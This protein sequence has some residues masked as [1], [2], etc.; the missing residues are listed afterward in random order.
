MKKNKN[1]N[2]QITKNKKA[3]FDYEILDSWEAWIE[4]SWH[5][6]KSVRNGHVNLK[7]AF[8]VV[9]NNELYIK[10]MHVSVWKALPNS[11]SVETERERK[12]FLHKK[13]INHLSWKN[14]EVGYSIIPLELYFVWSLIKLRVWLAK[15]KKAYQKK[16]ILK[17]RSMDREAKLSMKKFI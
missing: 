4:L 13:T 7:W 15:W 3:Y 12:I 1:L 11:Q 10:S 5:E 2:N 17:E 9:I 14:R 6:T 16:Q 8:I